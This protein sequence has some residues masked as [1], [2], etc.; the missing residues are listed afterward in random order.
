MGPPLAHVGGGTLEP[1]Q[2]AAPVAAALAYFV[3]ARTLA[4]QRR[5][6]SAGRQASF[7]AGIAL[8][9]LTLASPVAHLGEELVL[10]HM[11]QH[12]AM[13]DLGALLI[14][15]GLTG[16][17]LQ[18]VLAVRAIDRLRALAHPA[19][20]LPLWAANLYVWHLPVLYQGALASEWLHALQHAAFVAFGINMWMSLLGPLPMPEWFGNGAKLGYIVSVRLVG[21]LLANVLMWSEVVLYP[22]YAAGEA[23]WGI[24]PLSDQ[25]AAGVIMMVEGSILTI[26]LFGWLFLKA[27]GEAEERQELLEL[28]ARNGVELSAR[29]AA[30]AVG[31][32]HGAE[33]RRRLERAE[34]T[35]RDTKLAAPPAVPPPARAG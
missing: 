30:R 23:E 9:L 3:R 34:G 29:R 2:L 28:A 20:A 27:A 5:P 8:V 12:L 19:V 25:A 4:R 14:V 31:S 6:V 35:D 7:A 33:L 13:A 24:A 22:D 11:A 16:P 10:A 18:P 17:V 32:G 15:L 1:L 21:A 26:V